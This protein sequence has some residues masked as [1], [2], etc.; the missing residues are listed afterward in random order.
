MQQ[1]E[2]SRCERVSVCVCTVVVSLGVGITLSRRRLLLLPCPLRAAI[3]S[4]IT[5]SATSKQ[6]GHEEKSFSTRLMTDTERA[7]EGKR[8]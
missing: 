5:A 7:S 3:G 8:S 2:H 4:T 6:A 1:P